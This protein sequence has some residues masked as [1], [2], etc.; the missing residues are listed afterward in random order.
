MKT[1]RFSLTQK[2]VAMCLSI[3]ILI[4]ALGAFTYY[5]SSQVRELNRRVSEVKLAK[6]KELGELVFKFRN[7]RIVVRTIPV[8]GMSWSEVD[9]FA[10]MTKE[11]VKVFMEA[12]DSYS[13]HIET[14][15]ERQ[16]FDEFDR[17]FNEFLDFG[18]N[19][20]G[21]AA[22]HDQK[23][24]EDLARQIREICPV[25]AAKV[26]KAIAE[27]IAQQTAEANDLVSSAHTAVNQ[28]AMAILFGSIIGFLL[29]LVAGIL[30]SRA[31]SK[32]LTLLAE[33][34]ARSSKKVT[35]AA[36]EVSNNGSQLSSATTEQAAAL[37]ETVSAIEEISSM[38]A[39]N[40]ENA[41]ASQ[42]TASSSRTT[43]ESGK[44]LVDQLISE[45]EHI[46]RNTD[47]LVKTVEAGNEEISQIVAMISEIEQ[48][49]EVI[50]D[51]VFQTK[52]LSFNASVEAARAGE[53][54]KGFAVVAEEVGILAQNSGKAATEI[55][56]LLDGSIQKVRDIVTKTRTTTEK[57]ANLSR[58]RVLRGLEVARECGDSLG[59][60]LD[61]AQRAE[62]MAQEIAFASQ[63]Q[64]SGLAEV[65]KA[66][67]QLDQV[68]QEN[69][70]VSHSSASASTELKS[71][72]DQMKSLV[73]NLYV[74]VQGDADSKAG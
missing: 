68:T 6:T 64:A 47:Q 18:V 1:I 27:L 40:T 24:L 26:E 49:T 51:I 7:I 72:A 57:Q 35:S 19:I 73:G 39:R 15:R 37:Q 32:K 23:K 20:L 50:N 16:L 10:E 65:T 56:T 66:M 48:K 70:S 44:L 53:A 4:P 8:I 46:E 3:G 43:A 9:R 67:H 63:E 69:A 29:A 34:L 11:A 13:K 58:E 22:S 25:K 12:K 52:L 36:Q 5:K 59:R 30:V 33:E 62:Q 2:L 21:L 71:L 60:I 28:S 55:G 41:K 38:I 45:V 54:G 61:E 14:D 17:S 42:S 31:I 74:T